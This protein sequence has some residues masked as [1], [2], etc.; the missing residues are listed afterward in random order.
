MLGPNFVIIP[1]SDTQYYVSSLQ[2]GTP[3]TLD[4]QMQWIVNNNESLNI[5]YVAGL[6]DVVQDGN[7][8]GNP[9]EWL[10]ANHS[11][12]LLEDPVA[13]GRPEGIP[14]GLSVGNHDQGP[15]G[16]GGV[17]SSTTSYN[18]YFGISRFS[19]RSY[20]G[21]SFSSS[22]NNNHY[23]LFSA[24]GLDFVVVHL[25]WDENVA[26]PEF[27][28]W[29]DSILQQFPNRRAIVVTHYLCDDGFQANFSTQGQAIYNG[30]K[31]N[32]NL[33]LMLGG[34]YT[35][36]EGWRQDTFNGNRIVSLHS[37]YQE[38]TNGGNG[39]FRIMTFSPANNSIH[40]QTYSP[41]LN[42]FENTSAGDFTLP[43]AMQ[44]PGSGFPLLGTATVS[45]RSPATPL[46]NTPSGS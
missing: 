33:F 25:E 39:W 28:T 41:T 32:P 44:G 17:D 6:G 15:T 13:T 22:D 26:H 30:L 43:Y 38:D 34:H 46:W 5:A 3:A 9:S 14:Y 42:Q 10:N 11:F 18:Q 40:V 45:S 36:P 27:I 4:T 19:G 20:Y 29:A 24:S 35:P 16:N 8:N 21:G 7:N 23:D 1:V 2:G 12:S 31:G 37:D